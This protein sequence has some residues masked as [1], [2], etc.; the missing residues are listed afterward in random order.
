MATTKKKAS[1]KS[2]A[3]VEDTGAM[4][5]FLGTVVGETIKEED[6]VAKKPKAKPK[7]AAK[8]TVE[9]RQVENMP[10]AD[11]GGEDNKWEDR[12]LYEDPFEPFVV[13]PTAKI[14]EADN[15]DGLTEDVEITGDTL[16]RAVYG[17]AAE[18]LMLAQ[19]HLANLEEVSKND[20]ENIAPDQVRVVLTTSVIDG[21]GNVLHWSTNTKILDP[22]SD[23]EALRDIKDESKIS[24]LFKKFLDDYI[25]RKLIDKSTTAEEVKPVDITPEVVAPK[26]VFPT[27]LVDKW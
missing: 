1:A 5:E 18:P 14:Q 21:K 3:N 9:D 8:Q 23:S 7:S 12:I 6:I 10:E 25:Y 17:D 4:D 26:L 20:D 16:M 22:L 2:K 27:R 24:E 19:T 13:S 11:K 15:V